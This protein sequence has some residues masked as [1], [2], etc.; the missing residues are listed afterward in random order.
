MATDRPLDKAIDDF[1]RHLSVEHQVSA[2]TAAAYR[3][4][5]SKLSQ[6]GE[7]QSLGDARALQPHHLRHCLS[8]LHRAGLSSR[9]LQRWLSACRSFFNFALGKNWMDKDPSAG[10]Q[11]PKGERLLPKTLDVDQVGQLLEVT[12]DEFIDVR[13]RTMLELMYSCGLRLSEMVSLDTEAVDLADGELRVTGKGSKARVLPIGQFAVKALRAWLPVRQDH[14]RPDERAL[15]ISKRGTRLQARSV[16]KRFARAGITQGLDTP[17]HPHMLRHSFA[18]HM[19]ESSGDL[20]AVQELLGHANISTTQIYTHLDFQHLAK[21][22]DSA[23]PRAH[24][25]KP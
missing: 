5:L 13:D 12:G 23:H 22:Y 16:Q 10:I 3:R 11:A 18:S 7:Q 8:Q 20:R 14:L 24:R 1:L 17:L 6:Y 9:S 21:I 19:L 2:H 25:K 15:F 4:D